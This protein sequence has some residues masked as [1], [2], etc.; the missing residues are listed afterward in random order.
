MSELTA[1]VAEARVASAPGRPSG[2]SF[3]EF[4]GNVKTLTAQPAAYNSARFI[5]QK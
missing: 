2:N 3:F 5:L 4:L 1:T